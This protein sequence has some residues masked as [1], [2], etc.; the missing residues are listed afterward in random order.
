LFV[1]DLQKQVADTKS[2]KNS[3]MERIASLEH[4]NKTLK[5]FVATVV[6]AIERDHTILESIQKLFPDFS[7]QQ[8]NDSTSSTA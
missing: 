4:E 6:S 5:N 8:L 2:E 3:L 1:E 7:L